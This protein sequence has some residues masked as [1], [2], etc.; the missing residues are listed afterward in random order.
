MIDALLG[1][2]KGLQEAIANDPRYADFFF[3]AGET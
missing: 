2:L 3:Y 1:N